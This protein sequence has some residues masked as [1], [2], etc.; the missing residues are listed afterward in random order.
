[1]KRVLSV[2]LTLTLMLAVFPVGNLSASAVNYNRSAALRYAEDTWNN[3]VEM[4]AGYVSN[5]L[6]AGGINVMERSVYNLYNALKGTYGT[7]YVLTTDGPYIYMSDNVGKLSPADPVFYYC[8]SC[9]TFQH[10]I[11]CGGSD[12]SGR[13]TDYAHNNAHHN[14][15]TYISWGCSDCG[16]VNWTMYCVHINSSSDTSTA[17]ILSVYFNANGASINSSKY[18]LVSNEVYQISGNTRFAQKWTY[19]NTLPYGICDASGFGLYKTGY[20]FAGWGTQQSGGKVFSDQDTSVKPSDLSSNIQ[21]GSCSVVLYAQWKP[22]TYSVTYN[23]NG[24]SGAPAAQTKTHGVNLTLSSSKPSR[25]GYNFKCWNTKSDGTGTNYNPGSTYSAN[26]GV[27]LY[28]IWSKTHVH[29]YTKTITKAAT[30]TTD[31][32]A[33]YT[34]SCGASYT[35]T[36]KATGHNI[37]WVFTKIPSIY[38]TGLKHKECSKCNTSMSAHTIVAKATGDVNGDGHTNSFDAMA[39]L[40]HTTG[41]STMSQAE[42]VRLNADVN[43]DGHINSS[44]ALIIL[45]VATGSIRP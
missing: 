7:S 30:C 32:T 9:K 40:K 25:S 14:T 4:C 8:K 35:E 5:C 43:G 6:K 19:N 3:G 31:G 16:A 37:V 38:S 41:F 24:G 21:N 27:T 13:M 26:S 2:L 45:Q 18:K 1:M 29:S 28:A 23:A 33:K 11:L 34:C 17:K 10:A 12:S 39:V 44:D 15:T 20:T 42:T 36:I 22:N